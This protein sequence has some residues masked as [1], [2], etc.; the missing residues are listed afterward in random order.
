MVHLIRH[1]CR[2][3]L[4]H[5]PKSLLT[6]ND[7]P[8]ISWILA[9]LYLELIFQA[10]FDGHETSQLAV[11]L[12]E[13]Y[14]WS[15]FPEQLHYCFE[16][17]SRMRCDRSRVYEAAEVDGGGCHSIEGGSRCCWSGWCGRVKVCWGSKVAYC[18]GID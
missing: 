13:D 15:N 1:P 14:S 3:L 6:L 10:I 2:A 8:I 12:D 17:E 9:R 5:A 7:M 16:R 18:I 11:V 4:E